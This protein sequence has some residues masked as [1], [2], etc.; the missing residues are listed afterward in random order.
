MPS[1]FA[2]WR[3]SLHRTRADLPIVLAAFLITLLAAVLL[4]TGPIYSSAASVAGLHRALADAPAANTDISGS[5]YAPSA[6]V[7]DVD[8]AMR[9]ELR[10]VRDRAARSELGPTR[11]RRA[12]RRCYSDPWSLTPVS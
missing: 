7:S 11:S 4:A 6:H 1:L 3:L 5:L 12:I 9:L 8:A 2:A 10:R